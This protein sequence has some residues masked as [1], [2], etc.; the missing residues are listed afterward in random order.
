MATN[1]FI[2]STKHPHRREHKITSLIPSK[3]DGNQIDHIFISKK[4]LR[5]INDVRSYRGANIELDHALV[6]AK[7]KLKI[8]KKSNKSKR[9]IESGTQKK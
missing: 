6:I 5:T 3:T 7:V 1:T 4:W 9:Q 2:A 8:I